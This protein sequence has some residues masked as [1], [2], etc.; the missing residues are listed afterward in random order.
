MAGMP[1]GPRVRHAREELRYLL[2]TLG[3]E[4]VAKLS[5]ARNEAQ[6]A[7][8]LHSG[9]IPEP[10]EYRLREAADAA[11]I[12]EAADSPQVAHNWMVRLHPLLGYHSP[13]TALAAGR[14]AAVRQAARAWPQQGQGRGR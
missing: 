7:W 6:V 4:A 10:V 11:R 3:A 8:W 2:D 13:A 12:V 5:G 14:L 1:G 9:D